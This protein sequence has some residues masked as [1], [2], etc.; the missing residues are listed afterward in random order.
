MA[1]AWVS[2]VAGWAG[3]VGQG[4]AGN[5]VVVDKTQAL[6][7]HPSPPPP[8]LCFLRAFPALP[9]GLLHDGSRGHHAC[10]HHGPPCSLHRPFAVWLCR[11]QQHT[12]QQG[13]GGGR[14][15]GQLMLVC[16]SGAAVRC[17]AG[18]AGLAWLHGGSQASQPPTLCA[19]PPLYC[20]HCFC[21]LPPC[22]AGAEVHA[23]GCAARHLCQPHQQG[24]HRAA[25]LHPAQPSV[26]H[27]KRWAPV[28]QAAAGKR[29]AGSLLAAWH[30]MLFAGWLT[31]RTPP[32]PVSNRFCSGGCFAV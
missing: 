17:S 14:V 31:E 23:G 16:L 26:R 11:C 25:R 22:A 10:P 19:P 9:A 8:P 4:R 13:K 20:L 1:A 27:P 21:V 32:M 28:L 7:E 2:L 15:G 5:G 24:E 29:A 12:G 6:P 18:A 3:L 30:A